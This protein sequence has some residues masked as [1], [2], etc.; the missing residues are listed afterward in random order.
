LWIF[1]LSIDLKRILCRKPLNTC[2]GA[3]MTAHVHLLDHLKMVFQFA[4]HFIFMADLLKLDLNANVTRSFKISP[5][6]KI[7]IGLAWP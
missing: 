6:E 5:F 1:Y 4:V 7:L 3:N 2:F